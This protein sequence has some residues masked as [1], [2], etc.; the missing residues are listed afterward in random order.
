MVKHKNLKRIEKMDLEIQP[1]KGGACGTTRWEKW[2]CSMSTSWTLKYP[3]SLKR[4]KCSLA[5]TSGECTGRYSSVQTEII[6]FEWCFRV[7]E[8]RNSRTN[9]ASA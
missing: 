6:K 3:G 2:L 5:K 7:K 4:R 8:Q 1:S 9:K